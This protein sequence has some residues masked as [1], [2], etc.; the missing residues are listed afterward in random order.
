MSPSYRRAMDRLLRGADL[1]RELAEALLHDTL[2]EQLPEVAVGAWLTALRGKPLVGAELS[3]FA[4]TLRQHMVRLTPP[5]GV[6]LSVTGT[7]GSGLSTLNVST[8]AALV[9]A[10]AGVKVAKPCRGAGR[11]DCG[12]ADVLSHLGVATVTAQ[13]ADDWFARGPLV[14]LFEGVHHPALD[15]WTPVRRTLGFS[16]V[17]DVLPPL[18]NAGGA[19]HHLVG[20]ADPALGPLMLRALRAQ[21][22]RRAMVVSGAHGVDE[23]TLSGPTRF[24]ELWDDGSTHSGLLTPE[25]VGLARVP[26]AKVRGGGVAHNAER[27]V[28]VL[29]GKGSA[30]LRA[31]V[32]LNAGSALYVAGAAGDV[33]QGVER[34][35]AVLDTDAAWAVFVDV[36]AGA[37]SC[38]G[39]A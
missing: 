28:Q 35:R 10:A 6:V 18:G 24:W 32:A 26:F 25:D 20:V 5:E 2:T 13:C 9:C 36:R 23:L 27:F 21:G 1:P 31:L 17:L 7:G 19:R 3:G 14:W 22:A 15:H 38:E 12:S 4:T 11:G 8:M 33:E 39:G 37:T 30:E 29:Q 16:T 34:A